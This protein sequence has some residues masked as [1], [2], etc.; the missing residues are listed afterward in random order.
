MATKIEELLSLGNH[1]FDF[2]AS[3][4]GTQF[5]IKVGKGG[6]FHIHEVFP[7]ES[8][9]T[10]FERKIIEPASCQVSCHK[11]GSAD[12]TYEDGQTYRLDQIQIER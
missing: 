9:V 6:R 8:R 10:I 3:E 7:E 4:D 1:H 5:T 11:Y 2:V 12:S